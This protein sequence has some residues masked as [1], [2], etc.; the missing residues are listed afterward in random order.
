MW[1]A[2]S[3]TNATGN[4]ALVVYGIDP[5]RITARSTVE[6]LKTATVAL[7]IQLKKPDRFVALL[8]KLVAEPSIPIRKGQL[9]QG[10]LVYGFDEHNRTA[11]PF[12]GV[13]D[14]RFGHHCH[15]HPG[16]GPCS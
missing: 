1:R 6:K 4:A 14:G 7:H 16:P 13:S 15:Q 12:S 5:S 11:Y 9:P 3:S 8:D 10:V 2:I